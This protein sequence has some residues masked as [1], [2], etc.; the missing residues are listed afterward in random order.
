M[1]GTRFAA[2]KRGAGGVPVGPYVLNLRDIRP[3]HGE[4]VGGKARRL[5]E[6]VR[7]GLPVPEGFVVTCDA[8]RDH[9]ARSVGAEG[10]TWAAVRGAYLSLTGQDP[11]ITVAVRSSAASED[12]IGSS[13]AGQYDTFLGIRGYDALVEAI[14]ACWGSLDGEKV[15]AYRP[16]AP[17][18]LGRKRPDRSEHAMAV[19]VQVEVP[20]EVAGVIFTLNP[21][22]GRE[23][24]MLVEASWG[25]GEAVVGGLTNP[26]RFVLD[27]WNETVK[28][29]Q[30]GDKK[31]MVTASIGGSRAGPAS[32]DESC[33]M[34]GP[35][36]L[37]A[38]GTRE[39]AVPEDMRRKRTLDDRMLIELMR[40]GQKV[41]EEYGLPQDIEWA[42]G[43]GRFLILQ[44]RP[45]TA[46]S[47][48]PDF[49]Q[50]T[51]ANFREVMP[52][53]AS[54][55]SQSMSF[56]HDFA[57]ATEEVFRRI[58][59]FRRVDEGTQWAGTFFGHGYWNVGAT[60]RVAARVPGFRE[61]A[62]D[63]TVGIVPS[64]EGDGTTTPWT[65][66]TIC[67]AL[68]TLFAL[69]RHYR[70]VVREASAF[71]SWFDRNEGA[72]NAVS[73]A[74][75]SDED[76]KSW[77][78]VAIDLHSRAN[79]WA[80]VI[81]L[82]GTQAQ[83]DLHALVE[84]MDRLRR[85]G[86]GISEARLLTG[87]SRMATAGS[88]VALW[89]LA[90][91]AEGN[92]GAARM[93]RA[94]TPDELEARFRTWDSGNEEAGDDEP[95][96]ASGS[97]GDAGA[98]WSRFR[99]YLARFRY[100]SEVDED[101]AVPRW[102]EDPSVPLSMLKACLAGDLGE[103]PKLLLER[104]RQ[105]RENEER[106]AARALRATWASRLDPFRVR[107]F[108][109]QLGL[110]RGL[111]WW[112][113][114]TRVYLSRARYQTRRFLTEQ[115][116]RWAERGVIGAQ[117]DVFW[118]SRDEVLGLLDGTT[119]PSRVREAI[120]K[121]RRVPI[122]YR[123]FVPPPVIVP[124]PARVVTKQSGE[125]GRATAWLRKPGG[126]AATESVDSGTRV[127]E[128]LG[129]SAGLATGVVRVI[130]SLDEAGAL[131]KG[132]ILVAPFANPGWMPL[133]NLAC[134]IVLEEGGLLSHS[135]VV[136]RE[137]G[138]PAVLQVEGATMR[139][140]TGELAVVDGSRGLVRVLDGA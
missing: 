104:Q 138:I 70:L 10:Q 109:A 101:L 48:A 1:E 115:G 60:K 59:L 2:V 99:D 132:E 116:R 122:A 45:M 97:S 108:R 68:P 78:R 111:C 23:T 14:L 92:A 65:L 30:I 118:A 53:F 89:D 135:A 52:G 131:R 55:L 79:R 90:R 63:R 62:F 119:D 75:L 130:R 27:S 123:S 117:D 102:I 6:L 100:M 110:V 77:A 24:E 13:Y 40:L 19:I 72:W 49:G 82:L 66:S 61:R 114:E 95:A 56:H 124:G 84:K 29:A 31:V 126:A 46:F 38:A 33:G 139:L 4:L 73:P 136:A 87:I 51:S 26:D 96:G 16:G 107:G 3:E 103:D 12:E 11:G 140:R 20:A 120:A 54:Y 129:C 93:I 71:T 58:K 94:L 74:T 86:E 8:F 113:E 43:G 15:R 35:N 5:A 9:L 7:A 25:L 88:L 36:G 85:A 76:L 39:V 34:P 44:A 22:T 127:Y 57:R 50:W 64:Y 121:R 41:Q 28:E 106:K 37:G 112:R 42:Y 137:Y 47:F 18:R 105:V 83:D 69:R 91:Y 67:S 17:G 128:G 133:F 80:L 21:Q 125:P 134:G 98:F 81:S 32:G